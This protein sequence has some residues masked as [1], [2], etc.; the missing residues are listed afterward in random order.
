MYVKELPAVE[1]PPFADIEIE[2][3]RV[4]F[5]RRIGSVVLSDDL[6]PDS[7]Y[8]DSPLHIFLCDEKVFYAL[9]LIHDA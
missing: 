8:R 9:N 5:R 2:S 3:F 6:R 1:N 7:V 4:L